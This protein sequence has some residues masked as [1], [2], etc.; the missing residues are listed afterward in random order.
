[1][2]AKY[3]LPRDQIETFTN[4]IRASNYQMLRTMANRKQA[5]GNFE[6][7]LSDFEVASLTI[8]SRDEEIINLSLREANIRRRFNITVVGIYRDG[9]T[10][11][12]IDAET[13]LKR[14]D[15]VYVAGSPADIS[16]FN[17]LIRE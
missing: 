5:F 13:V 6:M 3:L 2:L 4:S 16:R 9:Q 11:H 12:N 10:I 14:G 17:I 8:F 15:V 1:V 7:E